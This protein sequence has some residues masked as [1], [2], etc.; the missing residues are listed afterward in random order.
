DI[1]KLMDA[2]EEQVIPIMDEPVRLSRDALVLGYAGAYSSFLLFAKRAELRYGVPSH[3]ILLEM[4]RRRTVGG[5]EDL[6][7]DIAIEMAA[8]AKH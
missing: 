8:I 2:A 4:A 1:F 7:E 3:Q 6:I 5:Q